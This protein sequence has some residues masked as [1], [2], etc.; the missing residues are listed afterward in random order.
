[1]NGLAT[2]DSG[3]PLWTSSTAKG[4]LDSMQEDGRAAYL[5]LNL[6]DMAFP[7]FYAPVLA[8]Q[9]ITQRRSCKSVRLA[10]VFAAVLAGFFDIAENLY[11]ECGGQACVRALIME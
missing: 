11:V 10:L 7:F 5:R 6:V 9:L 2:F 4:V 3:L 8:L 1:M